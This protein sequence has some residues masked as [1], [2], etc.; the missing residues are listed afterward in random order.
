MVQEVNRHKA[1]CP[2]CDEVF[3]LSEKEVLLF[4][5]MRCPGCHA[6]L[7]VTHVAPVTLAVFCSHGLEWIDGEGRVV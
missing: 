5:V 6:R 2:L 1:R 7:Q 4:M 3:L